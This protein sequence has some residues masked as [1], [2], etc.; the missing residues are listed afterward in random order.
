[1]DSHPEINKDRTNNNNR[2]AELSSLPIVQ[3]WSATSSENVEVI[4]IHPS[5]PLDIALLHI[6]TDE[7]L[8]SLRQS[9]IT[10]KYRDQD[11]P[12]STHSTFESSIENDSSCLSDHYYKSED[13]P[14][15]V[16][17]ADTCADADIQHQ[18]CK[19][20]TSVDSD[21]DGVKW[22]IQKLDTIMLE[23]K[24]SFSELETQSFS[25]LET[26]RTC[27]Q[28]ENQLHSKCTSMTSNDL[29]D[30]FIL[31]SRDIM[32]LFKDISMIIIHSSTVKR[33]ATSKTARF[34]YQSVRSRPKFF[35]V[36]SYMVVSMAFLCFQAALRNV[37]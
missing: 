34:L 14:V 5:V 21:D 18:D 31:L 20:I 22:E 27:A 7:L 19:S 15:K 17:D 6:K 9:A 4:E 2:K 24:Q 36:L 32:T 10:P 13:I 12:T 16:T 28:D 35:L 29:D 8:E 11:S 25:T 37:W 26:S 1:M 3:K 23:M 33:M 30:F